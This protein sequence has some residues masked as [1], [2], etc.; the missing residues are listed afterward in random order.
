MVKVCCAVQ[1]CILGIMAK[2]QP[3]ACLIIIF[4]IVESTVYVAA[5]P[6]KHNLALARK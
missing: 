2:N 4:C 6:S 5:V 1:H 3:K